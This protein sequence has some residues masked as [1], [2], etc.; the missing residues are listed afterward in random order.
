MRMY[1][2][3]V[4]LLLV[5]VVFSILVAGADYSAA[6]GKPLLNTPATGNFWVNYTWSAGANTDSFNISINRNWT[7][8]T[9]IT[10]FNTPVAPHGWVKI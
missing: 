6:P 3:N 1:K 4:T 10:Y 7:N 9:N 5:I 2:K 8:G